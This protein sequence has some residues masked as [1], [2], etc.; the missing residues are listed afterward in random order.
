MFHLGVGVGVQVI[1]LCVVLEN[2]N[3][4]VIL[5]PISNNIPTD[6]LATQITHNPVIVA[7][8]STPRPVRSHATGMHGLHRRTI[9]LGGRMGFP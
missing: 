4:Y 2:N 8:P 9:G 5:Y 6:H 3:M 7:S 1:S